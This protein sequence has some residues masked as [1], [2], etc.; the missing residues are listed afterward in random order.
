[1][2]DHLQETLSSLAKENK[3][4]A[5]MGDTNIDLL[6]Y[7]DHIPTNEF[8][9]MLFSYHFQ[10]TIL[11]PTRITDT[12][13]TVIDNIYLNNTIDTN[14][15]SGNILSMISDHLPQFAI[16]SDNAPDYKTSSYFAYDYTGFDE[17]RFLADYNNIENSFL[18]DSTMDLDQNFDTFLLR[19]HSLI[20][21]DCP[22]KKL[23]R[24]ALKLRNKPWISLRIQKMMKI[25]DNLFHQ[26]KSAKSADDFMLYKQFRNRIV[27]E[28]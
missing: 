12:S 6:K 5:I 25:R 18:S 26:F 17:A 10:P 21:T 24:K 3:L 22:K 15:N 1:M 20:D 16:L 27:N 23:N 4:I 7:D 11:H 2:T 28:I 9:N 14:I 8:V 19:L 13:S